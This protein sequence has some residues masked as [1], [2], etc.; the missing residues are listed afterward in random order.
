M[1]GFRADDFDAGVLQFAR[2]RRIQRQH[3]EYEQIVIRSFYDAGLGRETQFR[4]ENS[5]EETFAA[6]ETA[7]VGK[8][9]I[10]GENRADSCEQRVGS[11]THAMDLCAGF[12][13]SDPVIALAGVLALLSSGRWQRELSIQR[14]RRL[15]RDERFLRSNPAGE[16]LIESPRIFF[17]NSRDNFHASC[18]QPPE[19]LAR[20]YR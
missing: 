2:L 3:G 5:T 10:I 14:H 6:R 13:R 9:R 20:L 11:V 18:P 7:A 19:A 16:R 15:Q 12:F 8:Q 1:L 4:I 17:A